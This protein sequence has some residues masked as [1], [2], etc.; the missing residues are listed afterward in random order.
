MYLSY[1]KKIRAHVRIFFSPFYYLSIIFSLHMKYSRYVLIITA[2]L[3]LASPSQLRAERSRIPDSNQCDKYIWEQLTLADSLSNIHLIESIELLHELRTLLDSCASQETKIYY[4]EV[5]AG[6]QYLTSNLALALLYA[7]SALELSIATRDSYDIYFS[8]SLLGDIYATQ[9]KVE[10][11]LDNYL[12]TIPYHQEKNDTN[13]L[14]FTYLNL[15][16]IYMENE[17]YPETRRYLEKVLELTAGKKR[18]ATILTEA[19]HQLIWL[20]IKMNHLDAADSLIMNSPGYLKDIEEGPTYLSDYYS[21]HAELYYRKGM[22]DSALIYWKKAVDNAR[23]F[24]D[25]YVLADIL[26][27]GVELKIKENRLQE[28]QELIDEAARLNLDI[29]SK[30]LDKNI[31]KKKHDLALAGKKYKEAEW[32]L[33]KYEE[34]DDSLRSDR[35][36]VRLAQ[37]EELRNEIERQNL[38]HSKELLQ[39]QNRKKQL[40][41]NRRKIILLLALILLL[42]SLAAVSITLIYY[43]RAR[44]INLTK[45]RMISVI[46]HDLRTPVY[47]IE[48]LL[49]MA[50]ESGEME[51]VR[52]ARLSTSNLRKTFDNLLY[53]AKSQ[54]EGDKNQKE[55]LLLTDMVKEAIDFQKPALEDKA[56]KIRTENLEG[57]EFEFDPVQFEVIL[58]NLL[59]NAVKFTPR[60]GEIIIRAK[61]VN[62]ELQIEVKDSGVGIP[63]ELQKKLF[64]TRH[65]FTSRGTLNEKGAGLG[66]S[67]AYY[68]AVSNGAYLSVESRHGE[69]S[70]FRIHIPR[71]Q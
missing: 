45:D 66:L 13:N 68:F 1:H 33:R 61:E 64:D 55:K 15:A 63:E 48:Q 62:N 71:Q 6:N 42:V 21:L 23:Q 25:Q 54:L 44:K 69:G 5:A 16:N 51:L 52:K 57:I 56:I 9:G 60:G 59:S 4:Y 3:F 22:I 49:D 37:I 29:K 53:W 47:Q 26:L 36:S 10:K 11:A 41:L 34:F 43:R 12:Q 28:A 46:S 17:E 7:D 19:Y 8:K 50:I 35:M 30:V 58:R 39:E 67:L 14:A 38:L 32:Y 2:L 18:F 40:L 27:Q 65:M 70:T 24:G 31:F 20:N